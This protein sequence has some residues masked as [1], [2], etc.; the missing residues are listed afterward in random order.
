M[1]VCG[2]AGEPF[3]VRR[4]STTGFVFPLPI[5]RMIL[6]HPKS[7]SLLSRG[8]EFDMN[9]GSAE[10]EAIKISRDLVR[11]GIKLQLRQC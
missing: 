3:M 9:T 7:K 6:A 4:I 5:A 1:L 8:V 11:N 10:A 2:E